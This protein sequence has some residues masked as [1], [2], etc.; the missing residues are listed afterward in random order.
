MCSADLLVHHDLDKELILQCDASPDGV[1]AILS[2]I[3]KDSSK[4]PVAYMSCTLNPAERN[5][6]QIEK[7]ALAI[8]SAARKFH[9]YLY[10]TDHKLLLGLLY[11]F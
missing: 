3:L 7:E 9:P 8:I 4:R 5:Y 1:G 10:G 2:H 11:E 6:S